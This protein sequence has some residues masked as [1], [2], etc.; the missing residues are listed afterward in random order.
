MIYV[1]QSLGHVFKT[2]LKYMK[3]VDIFIIG[4]TIPWYENRPLG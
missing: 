1:R 4:K 3:T 2:N